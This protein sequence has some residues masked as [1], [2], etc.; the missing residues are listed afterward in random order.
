LANASGWPF[1]GPWVSAEDACKDVHYRVYALKSGE[2]LD[3]KVEC[4]QEPL[5]RAVGHEVDISEVKCPIS[6]NTIYKNS[7]LIKY[8]SEEIT[9][10]QALVAYNENGGRIELTHDVEKTEH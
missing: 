3:E 7:H 2:R 8:V 4:D 9:R 1:G 6:S 5:V 10:L